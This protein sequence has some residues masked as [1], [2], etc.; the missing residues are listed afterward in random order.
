MAKQDYPPV[1]RAGIHP[2]TLDKIRDTFVAPLPEAT[3]RLRMFSMFEQWF[4]RLRQLNVTGTLWIDGSF[5]TRKPNP[6]DLDCVLWHPAFDCPVSEV[7][8]ERKIEVRSMIDH[9][10]A[11]A[12]FGID[13]YIETPLPADK[14][15]REAYWRGLFGFQHDE[16]APRD[17]W[18]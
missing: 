12:V 10:A 5:V 17:L 7:S 11:K 18:S 1:L 16:E 6:N 2:M 14:M 13:L 9:A 8:E 15:A 3:S 4:F